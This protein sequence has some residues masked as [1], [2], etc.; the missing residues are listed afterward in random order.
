VGKVST[1]AP[2]VATAIATGTVS[3]M[4]DRDYEGLGFNDAQRGQLR[5]IDEE[6]RVAMARLEER[7]GVARRAR[8]RHRPVTRPS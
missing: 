4:D 2:N 6:N 3:A 8:R 1:R 7:E 5:A